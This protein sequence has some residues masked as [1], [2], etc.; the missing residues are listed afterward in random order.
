LTGVFFAGVVVVV[1]AFVSFRGAAFLAGAV[2]V[3]VSVGVVLLAE[4]GGLD[5]GLAVFLMLGDVLDGR[6]GFLVP[7]GVLAAGAGFFTGAVAVF[8]GV[9]AVAGVVFL[10]TAGGIA[11]FVPIGVRVAAGLVAGFVVET[12]LPSFAGVA[13]AGVFLTGVVVFVEATGRGFLV[14]RGVL[15]FAGVDADL[16][17]AGVCFVLSAIF[18]TPSI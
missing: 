7:T 9:L 13:L 1:L 15:A 16:V 8:A 3:D 11:F 5:A 17:A 6:I 18:A 14:P 4:I 10:V 12:E 2:V